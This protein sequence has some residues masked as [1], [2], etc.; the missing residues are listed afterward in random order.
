MCYPGVYDR[1]AC[2][3]RIQERARRLT[4]TTDPDDDGSGQDDTPDPSTDDA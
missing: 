4:A 3:E 1:N 2:S